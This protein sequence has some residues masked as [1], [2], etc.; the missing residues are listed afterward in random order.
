V[1]A[2]TGTDRHLNL[3]QTRNGAWGQPWR[4]DETSSVA[5]P[6]AP[7]RTSSYWGGPAVTGTSTSL[8]SDA[9]VLRDRYVSTRPARAAPPC[10]RTSVRSSSCG[11]APTAGPTFSI[12]VGG[13]VR[14]EVTGS[15]A[16]GQLK[17]RPAV[18]DFVS[19]VSATFKVEA[20][21]SGR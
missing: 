18:G 5:P 14:L 11:P 21:R 13:L 8:P 12:S 17:G 16:S 2:W 1:I 20:L 6:S 10:A 3:L 15:V 4:L 7:S 9:V 19:S